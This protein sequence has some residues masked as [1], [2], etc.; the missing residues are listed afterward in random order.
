M[1]AIIFAFLLLFSPVQFSAVL[2][3]RIVLPQLV[4]EYK[5]KRRPYYAKY[6]K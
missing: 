5:H 1:K 6:F 2:P 4:K 3:K